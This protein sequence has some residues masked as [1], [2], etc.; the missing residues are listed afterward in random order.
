MAGKWIAMTSS[1]DL[2]TT[3]V[4]ERFLRFGFAINF[5][6]VVGRRIREKK[7]VTADVD[8]IG[9]ILA[10]VVHFDFLMPLLS[11]TA[12]VVTLVSLRLRP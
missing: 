6:E 12:T 3:P 7:V 2:C 4:L 11:V 10:G 1:L 9:A 8:F 5:G